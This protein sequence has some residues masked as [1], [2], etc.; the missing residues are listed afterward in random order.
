MFVF[1]LL[2]NKVRIFKCLRLLKKTISFFLDCG[3]TIFLNFT[4]RYICIFK[5]NAEPEAI[6]NLFKE[7]HK[8]KQR[9]VKT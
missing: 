5:K 3:L 6:N 1:I 2:K 8:H 4:N 7:A 9:H